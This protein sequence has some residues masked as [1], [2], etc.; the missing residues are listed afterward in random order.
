MFF[1]V[2]LGGIFGLF[3]GGSVLTVIEI[4]YSFV[5]GFIFYI[6]RGL[7][8]SERKTNVKLQQV[9]EVLPNSQKKIYPLLDFPVAPKAN[10]PRY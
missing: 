3:L 6:Y 10:K 8:C 1:T 4:V 7:T 9:I 5:I 2:Q